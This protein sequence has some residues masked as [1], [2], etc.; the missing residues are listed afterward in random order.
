[1]CDGS[2]YDDDMQADGI[3]ALDCEMVGVRG[4]TLKR[5]DVPSVENALCRVS[6][7]Q[8][9]TVEGGLSSR[10][11]ILDLWVQVPEADVVDWRTA[12]TGINAE[13]YKQKQRHPYAVVRAR[14]MD[15]LQNRI[16]VGHALWNDLDVLKLRHPPEL[17]R[18]TAMQG[19]LRPTWR[20]N[21]LPSLSLLVSYWLGE[22]FHTGVHDSIQDA[23]AALRLYYL[24]RHGLPDQAHLC[25][26][27]FAPTGG[28]SISRPRQSGDLADQSYC[29]SGHHTPWATRQSTATETTEAPDDS[30]GSP[31]GWSELDGEEFD[32]A[33][34]FSRSGH[35]SSQTLGPSPMLT[36]YASPALGPTSWQGGAA[37]DT[38]WLCTRT[39]ENSPHL[40][41]CEICEALRQDDFPPPS[42][43]AL[44]Q[45]GRKGH[46]ARPSA[47]RAT[48]TAA[49]A[50]ATEGSTA[51]ATTATTNN[52]NNNNNNKTTT[53]QIP[54]PPPPPAPSSA[55]AARGGVSGGG[56]TSSNSNSNTNNS[57]SSNS[58]ININNGG[59]TATTLAGS[60]KSDIGAVDQ[61]PGSG[62]FVNCRVSAYFY[63]EWHPASVRRFLEDDPKSV[64]VLWESE[65]S[66]SILPLTDVIKVPQKE[67]VPA[68]AAQPP[69]P[70]SSLPKPS[71]GLHGQTTSNWASVVS[72]CGGAVKT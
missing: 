33:E 62:L 28:G 37:E 16:L 48:T 63:G 27:M 58:N 44:M 29:G 55:G 2:W 23:Y 51:R 30:S 32:T 60:V 70:R 57:S 42:A 11:L 21:L 71:T 38:A 69:P 8:C 50:A 49:A 68:A 14:V 5:D 19:L 10:K 18:D 67:A 24:V 52:N 22:S 20:P 1:M 54:T 61:G 72:R 25:E 65:W 46:N 41:Y 45:G 9:E 64:E 17:V 15:V 13:N 4:H 31:E 26:R 66:V 43:A 40:T 36:P 6:V 34:G 59:S 56:N 35:T 12:I 47:G 3:V 53:Y 7:V 39:F